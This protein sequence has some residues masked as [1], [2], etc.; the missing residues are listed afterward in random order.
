MDEKSYEAFASKFEV[1]FD[2]NAEDQGDLN[3]LLDCIA[4]LLISMAEQK[5]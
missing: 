3:R 5:R 1:V 4:D 2:P